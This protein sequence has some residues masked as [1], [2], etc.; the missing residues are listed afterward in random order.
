MTNNAE[1][2]GNNSKTQDSNINNFLNNIPTKYNSIGD[3]PENS[4]GKI[5][6]K[7]I[8]ARKVVGGIL[9][10]IG[11]VG[12]IASVVALIKVGAAGIIATF[13]G[14]IGVCAAPIVAFV[15]IP[16]VLVALTAIGIFLLST[17]ASSQMNYQT[18]NGEID[19]SDEYMRLRNK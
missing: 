7:S 10:G 8:A 4:N 2:E 15:A 19:V 14:L 18:Q 13:A 16:V 1:I 6:G 11:V 3:Y 12:T 9:T 5:N 17:K